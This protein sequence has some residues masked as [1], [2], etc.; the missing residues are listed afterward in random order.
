VGHD[1]K[2]HIVDLGHEGSICG[3]FAGLALGT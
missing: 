3:S 1:S 2:E